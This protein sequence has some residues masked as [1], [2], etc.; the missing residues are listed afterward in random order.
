MT[1]VYLG[2]GSNQDDPVRQLEK[3]LRHLE[4]HFADCRCSSIYQTKA[5]G[6]IHQNDFMNAVVSFGSDLSAESI[7]VIIQKIEQKMGRVRHERWGPRVIDIDFLLFG[8][9]F[10]SSECLVIPHPLMKSRAFVLMPL[11]ELAPNLQL[12]CGA[13]AKDCLNSQELS[14]QIKQVRVASSVQ[15]S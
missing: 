1:L 14:N 10:V 15:G 3:A 7:F 4:C 12:P 5:W 8:E 13:Y 6:N 2:L 11:L 9:G